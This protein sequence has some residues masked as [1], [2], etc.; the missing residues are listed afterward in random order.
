MTIQKQPAGGT[1]FYD[2]DGGYSINIPAE[3]LVVQIDPDDVQDA[4]S[5]L[6]RTNPELA[7]PINAAQEAKPSL[8][9]IIAYD[10]QADHHVKGYVTNFT[11]GSF[12]DDMALSMPLDLLIEISIENAK[13]QIPGLKAKQLETRVNAQGIPIGSAEME[14]PIKL[15]SGGQIAVYQKLLF[16]RTDKA[17]L[18]ITFSVPKSKAQLALPSFDAIFDGI[19]AIEQ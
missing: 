3:W 10:K 9:R 13:E 6:S 19:K 12:N 16:F 7:A 15:S 8:Y 1:L 2:Y 18:V 11:V 5:T 17:L 14:T 4:V